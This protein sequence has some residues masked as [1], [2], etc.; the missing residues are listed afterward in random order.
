MN[1]EEDC[2]QLSQDMKW[3]VESSKLEAKLPR[4]RLEIAPVLGALLMHAS[5]A[6][7]ASTVMSNIA[8]RGDINILTVPRSTPEAIRAET[9]LSKHLEGTVEVTSSTSISSLR[10]Q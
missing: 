7:L 8:R 2:T 4:S 1:S 10:F 6:E 9:Q 3:L 5:T